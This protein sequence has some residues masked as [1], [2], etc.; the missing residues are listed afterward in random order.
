MSQVSTD[1][2]S[3]ANAHKTI[4][5]G[6]RGESLVLGCYTGIADSKATRKKSPLAHSFAV[7]SPWSN[8]FLVP[9]LWGRTPR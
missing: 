3:R 2:S 9:G 8:G 6:G 7:P 5:G 1:S 4:F